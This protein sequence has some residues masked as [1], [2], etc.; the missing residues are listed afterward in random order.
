MTT[1]EYNFHHLICT[2]HKHNDLCDTK[3]DILLYEAGL[4]ENDISS[5]GIDD[6]GWYFTGVV[7]VPAD[8]ALDCS[9]LN[10]AES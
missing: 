5:N 3:R 4:S 10:L 1:Y 9:W 6:V 2:V 8:C 7:R